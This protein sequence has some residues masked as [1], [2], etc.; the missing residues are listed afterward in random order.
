M[1]VNAKAGSTNCKFIQQKSVYILHY[2]D[3]S[4]TVYAIYKQYI[5]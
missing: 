1:S 5:A 3:N 2:D 4:L